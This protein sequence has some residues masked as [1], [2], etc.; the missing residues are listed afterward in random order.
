MEAVGQRSENLSRFGSLGSQSYKKY[1]Q[2]Y[3]VKYQTDYQRKIQ[4]LTSYKY[5]YLQRLN[6]PKSRHLKSD[7][8]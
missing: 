8:D 1:Q 6:I 2:K 7:S 3:Q 4:M 5:A